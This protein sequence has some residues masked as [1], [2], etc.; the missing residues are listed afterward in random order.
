M[1]PGT[2]MSRGPESG[3]IAIWIVWARSWAEIPVLTPPAASIETVKA[4][5]S[6]ASFFA[7]IRFSPSRSQRFAVSARQMSPRASLA[8]KLIASG[9]MNCAAITRSP[10]FS[11]SSSSHTTTMRPARM[12]SMASSTELKTRSDT[13]M[14]DQPLYVL[15]QHVD[16]QVDRGPLGGG[17]EIGA[18]ERLRNQ[19]DLESP[20]V[21]RGH[22]QR[23][24][25]HRDRALLDHVAQQPLVLR[26]D[27]HAAGEAVLLHAGH[28]ADA[29]HMALH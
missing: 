28:P 17:A 12:S 7:V 1:C 23:H 19:R 16:L 25:V 20:L 3:S 22:R 11:R 9:V 6:G 14:R 8:M 24:A 4:V 13:D 18:L 21:E 29:V 10:S 27:P 2:T 15:R 5:S 26:L